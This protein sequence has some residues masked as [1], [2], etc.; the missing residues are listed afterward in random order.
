M[1]RAYKL[2]VTG[3]NEDGEAIEV[4]RFAGSAAEVAG[5]K[6]QLVEDGFDKKKFVSEEIELPTAKGELIPYLNKLLTDLGPSHKG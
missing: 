5:H 4:V 6:K 3:E 2:R 1:A